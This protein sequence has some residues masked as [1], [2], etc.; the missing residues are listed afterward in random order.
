[1]V[2]AREPAVG[3]VG[4]A[5]EAVDDARD[6]RQGVD[7]G[8]GVGV[9]VADVQDDRLAE[10]ARELELTGEAAAL[11][12]A[13]RAVV[14]VVEAGLADGDDAGVREQAGELGEGE[15]S[16]ARMASCGWMPIAAWM[17]SSAPVSARAADQAAGVQP[18]WTKRSTPAAAARAR[19]AGR[20]S[21]IGA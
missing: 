18:M 9:G 21:I 7:L 10:L 5:G 2:A 16:S 3:L 13:G 15:V 8:P 12:V 11:G 4:G 1:V 17:R 19:V 14:E 20:S 6:G